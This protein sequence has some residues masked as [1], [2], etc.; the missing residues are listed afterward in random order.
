MAC[1]KRA[2][3]SNLP[4][5]LKQKTGTSLRHRFAHF[6]QGFARMLAVLV[7]CVCAV[8]AVDTA[9]QAAP[10]KQKVRYAWPAAS[11]LLTHGRCGRWTR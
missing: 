2:R 8:A 10:G 3:V 11:V 4:L 1:P 7:L 5:S 6:E 9:A